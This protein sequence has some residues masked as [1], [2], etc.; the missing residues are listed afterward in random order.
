MLA[1]KNNQMDRKTNCE[2][3]SRVGI[4]QPDVK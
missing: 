2:K 3:R 1:Q 4:S